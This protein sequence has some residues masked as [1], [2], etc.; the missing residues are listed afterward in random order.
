M[1]NHNGQVL[2]A[3]ILLLPLLVMA[4][5][6]FIDTGLLY[7]EKRKLNHV[8]SYIVEYGMQEGIADEN[9]LKQLLQKNI[10]KP[11]VT[12][13]DINENKLEMCVS[14]DKKS[15]FS[16][17]FRRDSYEIKSCYKAIKTNDTI[18]IVRE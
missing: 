15:M 3:F 6:L 5:A 11:A 8:V 10:D 17:L 1:K 13:I 12:Q 2:V 14:Y 4:I 9:I 7:I 18:K 16:F